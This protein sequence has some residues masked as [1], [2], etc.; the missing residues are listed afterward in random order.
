MVDL[1]DAGPRRMHASAFARDHLSLWRLAQKMKHPTGHRLHANH[2][3]AQGELA[4]THV[5]AGLGLIAAHNIISEL[6]TRAVVS[7]A[8]CSRRCTH[9]SAAQEH[10]GSWVSRGQCKQLLVSKASWHGTQRATP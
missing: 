4:G 5:L 6:M 1:S 3:N 10:E 7:K 2:R 9:S 8:N